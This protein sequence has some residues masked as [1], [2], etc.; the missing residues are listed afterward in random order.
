MV[1]IVIFFA[2]NGFLVEAILFLIKLNI[3]CDQFVELILF[4][5]H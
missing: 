2:P 3:K 4:F 1:M 5:E